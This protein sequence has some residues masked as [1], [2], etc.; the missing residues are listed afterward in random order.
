MI[1]TK[2]FW[3]AFALQFLL[4]GIVLWLYMKYTGMPASAWRYL[5]G[6]GHF[7]N[8]ILLTGL[9]ELLTFKIYEHRGG[10]AAQG[11]SLGAML[12]WFL[13]LMALRRDLLLM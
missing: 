12:I 6:E 9:T 1:R 13:L 7:G 4:M 3:I 8:V 2:N 5:T 11:G 10:L